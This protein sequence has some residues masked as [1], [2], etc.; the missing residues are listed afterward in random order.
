MHGIGTI[1]CEIEQNGKTSNQA[2]YFIYSRSGMMA[3]QLL[4]AKRSHWSIEN[5]CHWALDMQFCEDESRARADHSAEKRKALY[6]WAYDLPKAHA[7][8]C[9]SPSDKQFKCLLDKA[10]L[11]QILAFACCS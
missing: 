6:H 5:Q 9:G 11:E 2:H 1:L 3:S 7:C 10:F 4:E 8:V